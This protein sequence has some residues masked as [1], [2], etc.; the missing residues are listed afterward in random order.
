MKYVKQIGIIMTLSF[1]GEVLHEIVPL[2]VPANIYGIVLLFL[3]LECK[4]I[5]VSAVRE[6]SKI[7]IELMP[8]MF[9]PAAVGLIDTWGLIQNA[10][11]AYLVTTVVSTFV[12]LFVAGHVTQFVIRRTRAKAQADEL[13]TREVLEQEAKEA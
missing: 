7:L 11:M 8:L 13:D 12:V 9:I 4:V 5:K 3:C 2:P 1:A 6:V 10:W